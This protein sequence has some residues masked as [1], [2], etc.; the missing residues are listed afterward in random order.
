MLYA[1]QME[2]FCTVVTKQWG[3]WFGVLAFHFVIFDRF[4]SEASSSISSSSPS[5]L[6]SVSTLGRRFLC[7]A[8]VHTGFAMLDPSPPPYCR[9]MRGSCKGTPRLLSN[10]LASSFDI[11]SKIGNKIAG[12]LAIVRNT[13]ICLS[14]SRLAA[15]LITFTTKLSISTQWE[16]H[17][18]TL[19]HCHNV[20]SI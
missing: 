10:T 17:G 18:T 12:K 4:S 2:V 15:S 13:S 9:H 14:S 1:N 19:N 20:Y 3:I 5:S 6:S 11:I 16:S 8:R 7:V